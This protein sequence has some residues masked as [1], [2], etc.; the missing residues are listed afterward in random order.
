MLLYIVRHGETDWNRLGKLQGR[1]DTDLTDNGRRL[2]GLTAEGLKEVKF[3]FIYSSP[4]RR[5]YDTADIIRRDRAIE[6]VTD[7][8]LLEA[9]FGAHEGSIVDKRKGSLALFFDDP[10][11]YEPEGTAES[12]EEIIGRTKSFLDEIIFPIER[13]NSNATIL[14]SGHGAVNK[15]LMLNLL[16]TKLEDFWKGVYQDNCAVNIFEI[17]DGKATLLEEAKYFYNK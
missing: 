17:K 8:R 10:V 7:E 9:G 4:L 5:A 15:G 1:T 3:D 6:I 14:I 11:R 16:G 12:Y 13:E 2:A